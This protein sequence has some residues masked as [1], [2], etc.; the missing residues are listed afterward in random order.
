MVKKGFTLS[1]TLLTMAILGV[2]AAILTPVLMKAAPDTNRVMFKKAYY[3][4]ERAVTFLINDDVNYPANSTF[5]NAGG[6]TLLRGFNNT[7]PTVNILGG[8]T[9]NKFCYLLA[10]T[11]NT[12][13]EPIYPTNGQDGTSVIATFITSDGVLWKV[14]VPVS[15]DA[16]PANGSDNCTG[17]EFAVNSTCFSTKIAVDVNGEKN[18]NCTSDKV[19]DNSDA[20]YVDAYKL[21]FGGKDGSGN[22]TYGYCPAGQESDQFLISV[23]YD[24]KIRVGYSKDGSTV[25]TDSRA[26]DILSNPTNNSK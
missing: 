4:L 12:V 3:T 7:K 24:G 2:L 18:P 21:L 20:S 19:A 22:P 9:Y 14:Y 25:K 17:A 8:T 6:I 11:L 16:N 13:G 26:V 1:E 5:V 10:D 23:R 15:D